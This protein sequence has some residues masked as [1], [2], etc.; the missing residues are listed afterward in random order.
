MR[1]IDTFGVKF[2]GR[3]HVWHETLN[4]TIAQDDE[5]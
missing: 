3:E 1:E 4:P 5:T 2:A